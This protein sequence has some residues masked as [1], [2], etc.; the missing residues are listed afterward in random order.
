MWKILILPTV[1]D[2]SIGLKLKF[3]YKALHRGIEICQES[4]IFWIK[5]REGISLSLGNN[6]HM[7]LVAGGR[8]MKRKQV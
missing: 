6:Q 1:H 8:M 7:K 3:I 2:Q 4:C 5:I